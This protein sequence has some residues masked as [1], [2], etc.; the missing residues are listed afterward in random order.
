MSLPPVHVP[1]PCVN[2]CQMDPASGFCLGCARTLDEIAGWL[3]MPPDEKL[4]ILERVAMRKQQ[5][6][7]NPNP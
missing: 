3:E 2:V 7:S 1:S 6:P 5:L 4:A